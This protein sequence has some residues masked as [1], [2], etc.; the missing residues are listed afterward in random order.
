MAADSVSGNETEGTSR[1]GA[2]V[3][4]ETSYPSRGISGPP[5]CIGAFDLYY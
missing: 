1:C 2:I 5:E 3:D 4:I